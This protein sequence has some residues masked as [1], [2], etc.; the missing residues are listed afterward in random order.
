[1]SFKLPLPVVSS[2]PDILDTQLT[3]DDEFLIIASDGLVR[4]RVG[5]GVLTCEKS[6][7]LPWEGVWPAP[8]APSGAGGACG[9]MGASHGKIK[10]N[11][12]MQWDVLS[13]QD[14]CQLASQALRA[15]AGATAPHAAK[16]AAAALVSAAL[17]AG[18]FDNVT[19]VVAA[20]HW[21]QRA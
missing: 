18:S 15:H 17:K 21:Q 5:V 11:P 12:P 16:A 9:V 7:V 13:N 6:A 14:A 4:A 1:M 19:A 3:Q 20:F 8:H 10:R 2:E